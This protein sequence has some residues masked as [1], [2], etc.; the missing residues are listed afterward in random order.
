M[1]LN[2]NP[3]CYKQALNNSAT[4]SSTISREVGLPDEAFLRNF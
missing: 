3:I 1:Q 2:T 4:S